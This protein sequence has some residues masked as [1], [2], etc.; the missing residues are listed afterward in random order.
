MFPS[1]TCNGSCHHHRLCIY[2]L[3]SRTPPPCHS[4]QAKVKK[5]VL[6]EKAPLNSPAHQPPGWQPL[7]ADPR[8]TSLGKCRCNV[9]PLCAGNGWRGVGEVMLIFPRRRRGLTWGR[10]SPHTR[11]GHRR[12]TGLGSCSE[13]HHAPT[14]SRTPRPPCPLTGRAAHTSGHLWG[15]RLC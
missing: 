4:R 2:H 5:R 13:C 11:C 9:D 7:A 3:F 15:D 10:H 12:C 6:Q 8:H 14:G 1:Q